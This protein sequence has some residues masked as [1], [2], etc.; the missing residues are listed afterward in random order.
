LERNFREDQVH[1]LVI[2]EEAAIALFS[3]LPEHFV[4]VGGAT[5]VLFHNSPRLSKDLDLLARRRHPPA[6]DC[7]LFLTPWILLPNRC[8]KR[9]HPSTVTDKQA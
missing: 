3:S 1:I 5:L 2:M 9:H 4:L 6:G 7:D 8:S